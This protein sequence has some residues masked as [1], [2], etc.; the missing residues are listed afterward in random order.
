MNAERPSSYNLKFYP[1]VMAD[2]DPKHPARTHAIFLVH[3]MGQQKFAETAA[4]LRTGFEDIMGAVVTKGDKLPP[5]YILEGFW[6]NYDNLEETFP[7]EWKNFGH[8][9][10]TFFGKL[11][12]L[13]THGL[14]ATLRWFLRQQTRL[15]GP[16]ALRDLGWKTQL[17]Y[18]PLQIL[19]PVA[20]AVMVIKLRTAITE[21]LADVRVYCA[22]K[23][24]IEGVINQG[25]DQRVAH[26][27]LQMLGLGPDFSPRD[28]SYCLHANQQPVRFRH[29]VWVAHSLGT[30]VSYN[31]LSDLFHQAGEL[32]NTGTDLQKEG[33]KI[34]R[35]SLATFVTLGSPLD[36]IAYLCKRDAIKPWPAPRAS[37]LS[38]E[39]QDRDDWW[40]NYFN[41]LDPVSGSLDNP[42]LFPTP[43]ASGTATAAPVRHEG[44]Q[45]FHAAWKLTG[46]IPGLAHMAYWHDA[47]I[48]RALL[49]LTYGKNWP[50]ALGPLGNRISFKTAAVG[51][52]VWVLLMVLGLVVM[53]GILLWAACKWVPSLVPTQLENFSRWLHLA[54]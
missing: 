8:G 52:L 18:L 28:D 39:N 12:K 6:A 9:E 17:I 10:Q 48:L 30:V 4:T 14:T 51:Y 29:V 45:N 41:V 38:G 35:A 15:V 20:L 19:F 49:K 47:G 11:W 16:R 13:R 40:L 32:A 22:P 34:F 5:P 1:W 2:L 46:L 53:F 54:S 25:I 37:L 27:F 33:V 44:P 7:A 21:V 23:G 43:P 31:A 24:M 42:L 50:E 3:G 36:K 26:R